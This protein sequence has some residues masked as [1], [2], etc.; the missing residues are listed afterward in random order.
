M[1][2]CSLTIVIFNIEDKTTA[3]LFYIITTIFKKHGI[4]KISGDKQNR[5]IACIQ[6]TI[7]LNI[8]EV[9]IMHL[10]KRQHDIIQVM[11][12]GESCIT[13]KKVSELIKVSEKTIR[14][15][16]K[17]IN[18]QFGLPIFIESQKGRGYRL[19]CQN[20]NYNYIFSDRYKYNEDLFKRQMHILYLLMD[21]GSMNIFDICEELYIG[22]KRLRMDIKSINRFTQKH[23]N[24][25]YIDWKGA[26]LT[27][28]GQE[29]DFRKILSYFMID[30][31]NEFNFYVENYQEYF[32]HINISYFTDRITRFFKENNLLIRDL[33]M[34][35]LILHIGI[36]FERILAGHM[37]KDGQSLETVDS[38]DAKRICKDIAE[39]YQ[40]SLPSKEIKYMLVLF[41]VNIPSA[42]PQQAMKHD[43]IDFI[44]T[45]LNE[46]CRQFHVDLREHTVFQY[47]MG[48]HLEV[49]IQRIMKHTYLKNPMLNEVKIQFPMAYDMGVLM[50][51]MIEHTFHISISE[52]EIGY[53]T[54]HL[55]TAMEE[56]GM[57]KK[58]RVAIVDPNG[59]MSAQFI[60]SRLLQA[61]GKKIEIVRHYSLFEI[62]NIKKEDIDLIISTA[63]LVKDLGIKVEQCSIGV[64]SADIQ[65]IETR[66]QELEKKQ[67]T[68]IKTNVPLFF[69]SLFF[70]DM[71]F[72]KKEEV[73]RF[74]CDELYR[75][76]FCAESYFADVMDR[77]RTAPTSFGNRCAIPHPIR[78]TA[79]RDAVA[80]CT[81][82]NNIMWNGH[83][84]NL[85]LLFVATENE[86]IFDMVYERIVVLLNYPN[87]VKE[88]CQITDFYKFVET[89]YNS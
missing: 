22:E 14:T 8:K 21:Y 44:N 51:Q 65:K 60:E 9:C 13:S 34:F 68:Y 16:I 89:F 55:M 37:V 71:E 79:Y 80:V 45:C 10:T 15:E 36:C 75:K 24:H 81:L 58:I 32:Y 29:E 28:Q 48:V 72:Q 88:L 11:P 43:Y 87:K 56:L 59:E 41:Y 2:N 49:M 61:L 19:N 18:R 23:F 67:N 64:T 53:L 54:L 4:L 25:V 27:I 5:G 3:F 12:K 84:V 30:V 6:H 74:L 86:A 66:I 69:E 17:D 47:N 35:T 38:Y 70:P 85:V 7:A 63:V 73:L 26:Y 57:R 76:G 77:E 78:R 20:P 52:D 33:D 40:V 31:I 39:Y 83:K 42:V 46:L 62:E 82:K 1:I 50:G